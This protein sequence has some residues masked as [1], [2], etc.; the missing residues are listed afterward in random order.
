MNIELKEIRDFLANT[1]PFDKLPIEKVEEITHASSIRYFRRGS[2][3]PTV[4][5]TQ[6]QLYIIRKGS[7]A[8]QTKN[9]GLLIGKGGIYGNVVRLSPPMNVTRTEIDDFIH[10]FDAALERCKDSN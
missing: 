9:D 8:I 3:M 10:V 4:N 6:N 5:V 7:I 2:P 1:T